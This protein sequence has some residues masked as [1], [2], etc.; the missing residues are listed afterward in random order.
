MLLFLLNI[1]SILYNF[2]FLFKSEAARS[3]NGRVLVHC[4]AGVSRS[5]TITI[6]YI[7]ALLGKSSNDAFE[8]VKNKRNIVSPNLNFMGQLFEFE[9]RSQ[10]CDLTVPPAL[11]VSG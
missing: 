2:Y 7:M 10:Y 9:Q 1:I 3:S 11:L 6:A 5:P 4:Q 8:F